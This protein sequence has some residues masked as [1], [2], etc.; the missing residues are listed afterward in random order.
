MY[1]I[2]N[3]KIQY[4]TFEMSK[5]KTLTNG[6][7]NGEKFTRSSFAILQYKKLAETCRNETEKETFS[8]TKKKE[9]L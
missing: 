4:K 6:I 2:V 5:L 8:E 1:T 7:Y 9:L 3:D